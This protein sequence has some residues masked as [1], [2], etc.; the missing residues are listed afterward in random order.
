MDDKIY[1]LLRSEFHSEARDSLIRKITE[2]LPAQLE[3]VAYTELFIDI[4]TPKNKDILNAL[5]NFVYQEFKRRE[6]EICPAN[7][8]TW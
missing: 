4:M 2:H 7:D 1:F 8:Y 3:T 6:Q 5:A